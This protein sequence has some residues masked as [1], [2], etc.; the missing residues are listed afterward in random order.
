M[1]YGGIFFAIRVFLLKMAPL[2]DGYNHGVA[3]TTQTKI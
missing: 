3:N 2:I 1:P